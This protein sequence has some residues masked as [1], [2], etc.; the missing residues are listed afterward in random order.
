VRDK[1][2]RPFDH[3]IH[4]V[5]RKIEEREVAAGVAAQCLRR[6]KGDSAHPEMTHAVERLIAMLM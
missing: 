4:A 6:S 3:D 1:P 2:T 5:G